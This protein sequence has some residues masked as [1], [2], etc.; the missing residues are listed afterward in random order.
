MAGDVSVQGVTLHPGT[1]DGPLLVLAEPLSLWG[2]VDVATGTITEGRH[3]QRGA[4]LAGRIL[5]MPAGRGSSSSSS[6]LAELLRV[7]RGPAGV[8]LGEPDVILVLGALAAAELYGIEL[9]VVSLGDGYREV[10]AA[11]RARVEAGPDHAHV[12]FAP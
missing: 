2:G 9:P 7:G 10:P 6:V 5:A 4:S 3:P 8:L 1:A 12:R 11:G